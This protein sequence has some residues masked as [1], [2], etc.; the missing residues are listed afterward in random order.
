MNTCVEL[1]QLRAW[2][3]T[4]DGS[5]IIWVALKTSPPHWKVLEVLLHKFLP[6]NSQQ[7]G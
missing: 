6:V 7:M 5:V 2:S 1:K 3:C 4:K